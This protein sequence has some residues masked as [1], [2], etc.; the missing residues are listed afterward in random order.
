MY[1]LYKLYSKCCIDFRISR[2]LESLETC[3]ESRNFS[4]VSEFVESRNFSRNF[5]FLVIH[6]EIDYKVVVP[7]SSDS[8]DFRSY[9]SWISNLLEIEYEWNLGTKGT[10]CFGGELFPFRDTCILH[11]STRQKIVDAFFVKHA[12]QSFYSFSSAAFLENLHNASSSK[13]YSVAMNFK[14][15]F[16]V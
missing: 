11:S 1:K 6:F 7:R 15:L 8:P 4:R 16:I 12:R 9:L 10:L 13:F 14:A 3:R 2:N 5:K